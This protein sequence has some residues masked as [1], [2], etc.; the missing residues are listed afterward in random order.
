VAFV[1]NRRLKT[2][3]RAKGKHFIRLHPAVA[4]ETP[5]QTSAYKYSQSSKFLREIIYERGYL[6]S[7]FSEKE[8]KAMN[9]AIVSS[10]V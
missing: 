4:N 9:S 5:L 3:A 8:P 10:G 7:C 2:S 1:S 6:S